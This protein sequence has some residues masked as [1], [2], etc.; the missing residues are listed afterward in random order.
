MVVLVDPLLTDYDVDSEGASP[1]GPH[2]AGNWTRNPE[3]YCWHSYL[4]Q[5][6]IMESR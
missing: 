6:A 3:G 2:L 5:S 4:M 1:P